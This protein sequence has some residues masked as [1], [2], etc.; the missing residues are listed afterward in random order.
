[1]AYNELIKNFDGRVK[2]MVLLGRDGR[3]IAETADNPI[4]KSIIVI[5]N[6]V[7]FLFDIIISP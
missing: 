3:I 5:T 7:I 1:M 2:H 6:K 4:I